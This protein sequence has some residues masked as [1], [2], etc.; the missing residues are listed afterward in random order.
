MK[1]ILLVA[2][3]V[4]FACTLSV[5][6]QKPAKKAVKADAVVVDQPTQKQA[7]NALVNTVAVPQAAPQKAGAPVQ[8]KKVSKNAKPIQAPEQAVTPGVITPAQPVQAPNTGMNAAQ[9]KVATGNATPAAPAKT[10]KPATAKKTSPNA[11]PQAVKQEV[12]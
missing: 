6:A 3:V 8:G 10:T 2:T 7:V 5:N 12:K 4:A 1:K 11:K 9:D